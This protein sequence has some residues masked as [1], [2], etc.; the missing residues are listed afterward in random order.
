MPTFAEL[1]HAACVD[2]AI[3]PAALAA[4]LGLSQ[5]YL[6][7][8]RA[9]RRGPLKSDQIARAAEFLDVSSVPMIEASIAERG[10]VELP[11]RSAFAR[12]VATSLA[13]A[14][15]VMTDDDLREV[16]TLANA[17][18]TRSDPKRRK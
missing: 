4:H 18:A 12:N 9:G 2:A 14:W 8:V 3:K 5:T 6:S 1:F 17:A 13:A 10:A 16:A 7:D 15:G 11:A